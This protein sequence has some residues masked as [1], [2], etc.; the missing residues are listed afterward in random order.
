M[1][2]EEVVERLRRQFARAWPDPI[3]WE[4]ST[5]AIT[6]RLPRLSLQP[7]MEA[8]G[9]LSIL[10]ERHR[11]RL[12]REGVPVEA[13]PPPLPPPTAGVGNPLTLQLSIAEAGRP[14]PLFVKMLTPGPNG[15]L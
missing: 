3:R 10:H 9:V 14:A 5:R 8:Y 11:R 13:L 6:N 15:G 4:F 12:E 2:R 1:L 7:N